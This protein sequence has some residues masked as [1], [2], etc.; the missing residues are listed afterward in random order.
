MITFY[1]SRLQKNLVK[2]KDVNIKKQGV[3]LRS[4]M[5]F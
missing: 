5:L 3:F 4:P 2:V 1:F